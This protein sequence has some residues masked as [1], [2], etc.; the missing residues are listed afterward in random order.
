MLLFTSLA[1]T[2]ASIG[3]VISILGIFGYWEKRNCDDK[4]RNH[5]AFPMAVLSVIFY[6]LSI[7]L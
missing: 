6:V 7:I 1:L 3:V 2:I 4:M 5:I